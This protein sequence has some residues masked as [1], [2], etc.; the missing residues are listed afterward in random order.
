M[1]QKLIMVTA[2]LLLFSEEL[3]APEQPKRSLE[4]MALENVQVL[5]RLVMSDALLGQ[6]EFRRCEIMREDGNFKGATFSLVFGQEC[7]RISVFEDGMLRLWWGPERSGFA[8]RY[9]VVVS[10]KGLTGKICEG[11]L[12]FK[13]TDAAMAAILGDSMVY[14]PNKGQPDEVAF[15]FWQQQYLQRLYCCREAVESLVRRSRASA[16]LAMRK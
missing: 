13:P 9:L 7:V 6:K 5:Y 11:F 8:D 16:D 1:N 14:R 2:F 4:Q 12:V 15:R 3:L 10:D